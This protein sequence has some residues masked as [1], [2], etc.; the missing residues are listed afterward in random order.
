MLLYEVDGSATLAIRV[1]KELSSTY[2][3]A[4]I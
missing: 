4:F 2:R 3:N 1:V